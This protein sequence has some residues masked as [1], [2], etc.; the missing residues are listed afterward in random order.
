M[1]TFYFD[2]VYMYSWIFFKLLQKSSYQMLLL[3]SALYIP[4]SIVISDLHSETKGSQFEPGSQLCAEESSLQDH[5]ANAQSVWEV[6]GSS[7]EKL[8]R[9]LSPS[10]RILSI[11]NVREKIPA[12][13]KYVSTVNRVNNT[14]LH[15][16]QD[17]KTKN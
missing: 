9:Q 2:Q 5:L 12:R 11:V 6:V 7:R 16:I 17:Q 13:K 3:Q 1:Y 8:K 15:L 14:F 10:P 4:L